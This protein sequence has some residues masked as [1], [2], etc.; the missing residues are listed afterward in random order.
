MKPP[1]PMLPAS[2]NVTARTNAAAMAES[3]KLNE[4]LHG[5]KIE[6]EA[7]ALRR[8]DELRAAVIRVDSFEHYGKQHAL[9]KKSAGKAAIYAI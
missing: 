9:K 1:P 8:M 6:A 3:R 7:E 2:G 5:A 4:R